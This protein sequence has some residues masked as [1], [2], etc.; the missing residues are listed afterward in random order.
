M[1]QWRQLLYS[2]VLAV[3]LSASAAAQTDSSPHRVQMVTVEQVALGVSRGDVSFFRG[4]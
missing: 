1:L 2:P 4:A 3:V